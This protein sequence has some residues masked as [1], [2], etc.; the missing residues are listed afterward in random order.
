MSKFFKFRT[1]PPLKPIQVG[2]FWQENTACV[3]YFEQEQP[4]S[5]YFSSKVEA[6]SFLQQF[7][8]SY[9]LIQAV[10]YSHIWRKTLILPSLDSSLKIEQQAI[11]I[12]KQSLPLD[13]SEIAFDYQVTPLESNHLYQMKLYALRKS[14]IWEDNAILDCELHCLLR[15]IAYLSEIVGEDID[16]YCYQFQD[17]FIQYKDQQ[18]TIEKQNLTD[19]P[20]FNVETLSQSNN[21]PHFYPYLI[22]LG[23]S[24]WNGKASI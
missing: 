5:F 3:V 17:K 16:K 12:L 24:L 11:Q 8:F 15:G 1:T 14:E 18:L 7:P 10:S 2:F 13:L 19:N 20:V 22:A 21:I 23:A 6:D 9:Q 4:H